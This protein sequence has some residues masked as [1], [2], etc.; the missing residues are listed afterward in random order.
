MTLTVDEAKELSKAVKT[1]NIPF[2]SCSYV[3]RSSDDDG[4]KELI[5]M[6]K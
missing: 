5:K 1:K 3:Y 4:C 6:E 2:V